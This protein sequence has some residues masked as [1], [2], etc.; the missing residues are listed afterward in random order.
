[1]AVELLERG[2][3]VQI[4]DLEGSDVAFDV[5]VRRVFLRS[6]LG[7]VDRLDDI[8]NRARQHHPE[9]PGSLDGLAWQIGRR[10]CRPIGY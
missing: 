8:V 6:A 5:H 7:D 3:G 1:M 4:R 2:F 9:R 10:W